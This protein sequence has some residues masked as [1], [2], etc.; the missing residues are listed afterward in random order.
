VENDKLFELMS[1]MYGEM[2][3][4]FKEVNSR[5]GNVENE[6]K[7]LKSEVVSVKSDL[8]EFRI[9]TNQRSDNLEDK[10]NDLDFFSHKELQTKK[11]MYHI[12]QKLTRSKRNI[13]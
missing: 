11:E 9:E 7:D 3:E 10:L 12:K 4:G 5:I 13:K 6:V 1:K 2:Q 8:N